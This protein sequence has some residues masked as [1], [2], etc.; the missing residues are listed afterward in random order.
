MPTKPPSFALIVLLWALAACQAVAPPQAS[1]TPFTGQPRS[2]I[3][4]TDMAGDDWM[5]ILYLLQRPDVEVKAI[6]VAGTGEAHCEPGVRH[7]LEL[8]ALSGHRAIPVACG[9]E[10]PLQGEHRFPISWC[11]AVD[12]LYGLT[13][14]AGSNP[15]PDQSAIGL[16]TSLIQASPQKT[17][18]LT[19]GPLT[20]LAEALQ[21]TP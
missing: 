4:D 19:L 13:L 14:P 16:L 1:P 21:A 6:T 20:N 8:V 9:R 18:V 12:D 11:R 7:A 3:I 2:V 17:T 5:A 10:T 15:A